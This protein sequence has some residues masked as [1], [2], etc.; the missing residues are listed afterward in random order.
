M[1]ESSK[2]T[3]PV[4]N[5]WDRSGLPGWSYHSPALFELERTELFLRHWQIVGH[6]AD[7]PSAGDWITHDILGERA[8]VMRGQD[9]QLRAF[10][11]LCR[12]RGARV[13]DGT[14]GKCRSAIVCPFH[15]WVYNLDGS[16]RGVSRPESFDADMDLTKMGLKPVE[17]EVWFGFIFLRFHPGPQP[18][19]AELLSPYAEDFAAYRCDE[20]VAV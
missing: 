2:I 12:H 14:S 10:H 11:N 9:G 1:N 17:I 3:I 15:G 18:S 16:L 19:V 8:I 13:V 20:L 4:P 5:K 7:V 6:E